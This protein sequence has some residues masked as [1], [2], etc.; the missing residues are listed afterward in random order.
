MK[1]TMVQPDGL[2]QPVG[3][4]SQV[5]RVECQ[6][7]AFVAGQ[8]AVAS[9]GTLVGDG[10]FGAQVRQVFSN[11]VASAEAVGAS[12]REVVKMTTYLVRAQDIEE[13]FQVREELFREYFRLLRHRCGCREGNVGWIG[14]NGGGILADSVRTK[15]ERVLQSGA[16]TLRRA[17][18]FGAGV[19]KAEVTFAGW[20]PAEGVRLSLWAYIWSPLATAAALHVT[21]SVTEP[22]RC[23]GNRSSNEMGSD[24]LRPLWGR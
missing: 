18:C 16:S 5:C 7:Y 3:Q 12:M 19:R 10:D 13:F 4:Y 9:D 6:E 20:W 11:L 8:L 24:Q 23:H 22:V 21:L 2:S 15:R 14:S 1:L 17:R